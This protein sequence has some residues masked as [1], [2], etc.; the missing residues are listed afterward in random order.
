VVDRS[1][2]LNVAT[3]NVGGRGLRFAEGRYWVEGSPLSFFHY[4]RVRLGMDVDSYLSDVNHHPVVRE[5]VEDYLKKAERHAPRG[6]AES[7][8]HDQQADGALLPP[9]VYR[10]IRDTLA[11]GALAFDPRE[12]STGLTEHLRG[13]S[14]A[15][16]RLRARLRVMAYHAAHETNPSVLEPNIE[17][18]QRSRLRRTWIDWWYFWNGPRSVQMPLNWVARSGWA[19]RGRKGLTSALRILR[20]R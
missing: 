11:E 2:S 3:W 9:V 7:M 15:N 1:P 8:R 12:L 6:R 16:R 10:A 17:H 5:L 19:R 18:Y 14:F 20:L 4:H 13:L